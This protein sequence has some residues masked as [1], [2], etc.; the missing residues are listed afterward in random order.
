MLSS[1]TFYVFNFPTQLLH[2]PDQPA[3][4]WIV[5][6][7]GFDTYPAFNAHQPS[8]SARQQPS[9]LAHKQ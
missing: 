7:N 9:K 3:I 5:L 2:V 6:E 8:S 4:P 1:T